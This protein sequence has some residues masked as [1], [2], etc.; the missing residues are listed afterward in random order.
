MRQKGKKQFKVDFL[1]WSQK[2]LSSSGPFFSDEKKMTYANILSQ[3]VGYFLQKETLNN[4]LSIFFMY[5]RIYIVIQ[6]IDIYLSCG[7][8]FDS[9]RPPVRA[10]G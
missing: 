8:D 3:H 4:S 2:G 9:A 5:R 6:H 1:S 10:A 7:F